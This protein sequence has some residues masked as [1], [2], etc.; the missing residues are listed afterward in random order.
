VHYDARAP[1]LID[2]LEMQWRVTVRAQCLLVSEDAQKADVRVV[3]LAPAPEPE[4]LVDIN[5]CFD[6]ALEPVPLLA[7]RTRRIEYDDVPQH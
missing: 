5:K 3:W 2:K 6:S 4:Y 7:V 1:Y